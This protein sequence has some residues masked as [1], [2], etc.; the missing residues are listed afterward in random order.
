M[1]IYVALIADESG[2]YCHVYGNSSNWSTY[3]DQLEDLGAEVIEDQTC[4]Y[5]DLHCIT[6]ADVWTPSLRAM[7]E[8]LD[9]VHI[10]RLI[11]NTDFIA[12]D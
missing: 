9:V 5:E 10:S 1:S 12:C 8:D 4:D 3:V 6:N 7:E 11:K 2:R